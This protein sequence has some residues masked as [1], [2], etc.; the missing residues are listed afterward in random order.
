MK[1]C[2]RRGPD[3]IEADGAVRYRPSVEQPVWVQCGDR[4][5]V[6][7]LTEWRLPAGSDTW[8][9]SVLHLAYVNHQWAATNAWFPAAR[10]TLDLKSPRRR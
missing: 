6:G 3:G 8:E 10:I 2:E 4:R 7:L 9:G 5:A 1:G